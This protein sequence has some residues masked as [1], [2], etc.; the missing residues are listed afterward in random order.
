MGLLFL[1]KSLCGGKYG[2]VGK[3]DLLPEFFTL[4]L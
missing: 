1:T 4:G 2:F 3:L